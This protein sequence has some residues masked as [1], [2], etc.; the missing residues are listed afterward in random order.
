M[1]KFTITF[2]WVETYHSVETIEAE[3]EDQAI[4]KLNKFLREGGERPNLWLPPDEYPFLDIKTVTT[5]QPTG[6]IQSIKTIKG[7]CGW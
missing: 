4:K 1:P 3:T 7:R 5:D 2:D 6:E